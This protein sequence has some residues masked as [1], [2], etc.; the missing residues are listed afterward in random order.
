MRS[1]PGVGDKKIDQIE[2]E[3]TQKSPRP[4]RR[5]V[6]ALCIRHIGE[7]SSRDLVDAWV[8]T[9]GVDDV[10]NDLKSFLHFV[11]DTDR[12]STIYGFGPEMVASLVAFFHDT[13]NQTIFSRLDEAGMIDRA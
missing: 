5:V 4:L 8:E 10:K 9:F 12:L 13:T 3:F 1:L 6:H 7:V 2:Q 11:Q